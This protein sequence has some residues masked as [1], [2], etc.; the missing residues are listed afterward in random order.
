M[1]YLNVL[2]CLSESANGNGPVR[3]IYHEGSLLSLKLGIRT[4]LFQGEGGEESGVLR[5]IT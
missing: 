1:E 5:K 3:C 2:P 4:S